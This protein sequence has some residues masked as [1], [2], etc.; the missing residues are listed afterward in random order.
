V[1]HQRVLHADENGLRLGWTIDGVETTTEFSLAEQGPQETILTVSQSHFDFTDVITG[2]SVRGALQTYWALTLSN[3]ADYLEGRPPTPRT[4]FTG[5]KEFRGEVLIA[6]PVEAVYRSMTDSDEASRWFGFPIGIEP[7]KGGRF[8]MGGLDNNPNP[9]LIVDIEP[10]RSMTI[11]WGAGG[12]VSTW[13]LA[14]SDGR[15]RL[16]FVQSGFDE[17]NPPYAAWTGWLSGVAELRRY[18]EMP[19]WQPLFL[20]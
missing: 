8:A 7:V 6:A 14:D 20:P 9:A 10:N 16:T 18:H 2:A 3:L 17:G 4:D 19:N 15:T 1:P 13:E 12:G 5:G 11:D